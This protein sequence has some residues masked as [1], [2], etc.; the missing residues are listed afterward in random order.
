MNGEQAGRQRGRRTS[1]LPRQ[2]TE[3]PAIPGEAMLLGG[4][5]SATDAIV[6]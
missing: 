5:H 6:E 2:K 1:E 3:K 4:G